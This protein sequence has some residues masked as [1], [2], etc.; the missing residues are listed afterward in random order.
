MGREGGKNEKVEQREV[1]ATH[2]HLP[3]MPVLTKWRRLK[4]SSRSF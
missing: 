1:S 3:R 4:Y 2:D